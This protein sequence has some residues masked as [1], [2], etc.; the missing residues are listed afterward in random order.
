MLRNGDVADEV[1]KGEDLASE[2][3]RLLRCERL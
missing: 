2:C 3:V 1:L